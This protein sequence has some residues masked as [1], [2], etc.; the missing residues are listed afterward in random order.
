MSQV[1]IYTNFFFQLA[2]LGCALQHAQLRDG[3]RHLLQL[4]PPDVT[5]V[6]SLQ[7]LFSRYKEDE[8]SQNAVGDQNISVESLFFLASPSQVLYNLEVT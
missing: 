5:T 6:Q 1:P 7:W 3:A 2:D 4:I 8:S